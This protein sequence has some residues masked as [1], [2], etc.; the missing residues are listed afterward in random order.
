MDLS[1][2]FLLFG[3]L[4]LFLFG[5]KI[6]SD[7]L[8]Q[9]AGARM[10]SVL[11]FFTT[12]RLAG[13]FVG[14]VFTAI[15]QSSSATTVM[16][17]SF[18]NSGLMTLYQAAGVILGANI[19]TT[20]TGQLIAFN[21]SELAPLFVM[22]GVILYMF[23]KGTKPKRIGIIIL[24]FGVLFM[25]LSTM[26]SSMAHLKDSP[27]MLDALSSLSNPFMAILFGFVITAV[28]QSSSATVGIVILMAEQGILQLHICLFLILGCNMGSCVSALFASIGGKKDAKRA[29]WIHFLFNIVGSAIMLVIFLLAGDDIASFIMGLS[30][31]NPGRAVA[32]AH[33]L[34]K[35][36]EVIL[37][38]GFMGA[39]VRATYRI[40]PGEDKKRSQDADLLYIRKR[41][42]APSTA[43]IDA[44][45]EL[46]HMGQVSLG[47]VKRSMHALC[48]NDKEA[49][50]DVYDKEEFINYLNREITDY[51]VNINGM[52]IPFEDA[53]L[54]GGLFHVAND[55]ERVGDHAE[56]FADI[57]ERCLD[58]GID[59]SEK[60][61]KQ[62][63][64]MT[65]LVDK[66]LSLSL[67]TFSNRTMTHVEEIKLLEDAVDE[68]ER[69]LQK[70]H[71]K[72]IA[73]GKCTLQA[74]MLFTDVISGLERIA[75]HAT[76]IAFSILEPDA[77]D[78]PEEE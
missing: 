20:V 34:I 78:E 67:R 7:G 12:N 14:I 8:E 66:V 23:C 70:S 38:F 77:L 55:L 3:G 9:A 71:V 25:G 72:R 76:N 53:H 27:R 19:G 58:E 30:N 50:Q 28:L 33:T 57:A 15:I 4:G 36:C 73:S 60:A 45:R 65:E 54:I 61:K 13:M 21:L 59:F 39:V 37:L 40:I 29:A 6:M 62:L 46:E 1:N 75:D 42:V 68:M 47:N 48:E 32:N 41:K 43:V 64:E 2:I 69:A 11:E 56:N 49:I 63:Y 22:A 44:I 31:G 35:I 18:V 10:R 5:M 74:G 52:E 51:L 16:V 17:V 24:G 26:S